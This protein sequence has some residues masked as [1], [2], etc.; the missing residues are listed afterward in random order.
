MTEQEKKINV[1]HIVGGKK[2][3]G[4]FKGAYIFHKALLGLKINSKILNDENNKNVNNE[5]FIYLNK[6]LYSNVLKNI[7]IL[8]EKTLKTIFLHSPRETFTF[9][10][11]GFDLTKIKEYKEAD[12]IHI[13]WLG[14]GFINLKSIS[15]I[16]KPVVW[17][18]R[19]MWPLTGGSHYKMDFEKYERSFLAKFVRRFKKNCFKEN[20]QFVTTSKWMKRIAEQSEILKNKKIM[21]IDNN[22]DLKNFNSLSKDKAR[23]NLKIFTKKKIILYGAQNPQSKRKGWN[24]FVD[25]LRQINKKEYF[26]LIFGKF[27]SHKVLDEIGIEYKS[28]GFIN[29]TNLLNEVYSSADLFVA[30]S[31]HDAWPKTFAEA[32]YCGTPVVCFDNTSISEIVDH[33]KNGYVVNDFSSNGLKKGIEWL[34]NEVSKNSFISKHAAEKILN[35]DPKIIASKYVKIYNQLI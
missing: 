4:V 8:I 20:I 34:A 3:N 29:E 5:N 25:A 11:F 22:I 7:F 28:M 10:F 24:L 31:I 21:Q 35:Y 33:K 19:D 13:H 14:E 16:K 26:L 12:I 1:L 32:M 17:T 9:N 15:K 27:W 18:I 2:S 6:S 23:N 30:S